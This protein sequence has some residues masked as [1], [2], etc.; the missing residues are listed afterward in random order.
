MPGSISSISHR[1]QSPGLSINLFS[2]TEEHEAQH[3]GNLDIKII[4]GKVFCPKCLNQIADDELHNVEESQYSSY[5]FNLFGALGQHGD[6]DQLRDIVLPV[7][8]I[9]LSHRKL[10]ILHDDDYHSLSKIVHKIVRCRKFDLNEFSCLVRIQSGISIESV[11]PI[12]LKSAWNAWNQLLEYGQIHVPTSVPD[13]DKGFSDSYTKFLYSLFTIVKSYL[14]LVNSHEANHISDL[15]FPIMIRDI[16][17]VMHR[18]YYLESQTKCLKILRENLLPSCSYHISNPDKLS[19]SEI[20]MLGDI[21]DTLTESIKTAIR[22]ENSDYISWLIGMDYI[23]RSHSL[24]YKTPSIKCRDRIEIFL[25]EFVLYVIEKE[26][27]RDSILRQHVEIESTVQTSARKVRSIDNYDEKYKTIVFYILLNCAAIKQNSEYFRPSRVRSVI[28]DDTEIM[29]EVRKCFK[30]SR[31]MMRAHALVTAVVTESPSGTNAA[32]RF[33]RRIWR[34]M[35]RN[36]SREEFNE[37]FCFDEEVFNWAH[38]HHEFYKLVDLETI[39]YCVKISSRKGYLDRILAKLLLGGYRNLIGRQ[40]RICHTGIIREIIKLNPDQIDGRLMYD[41]AILISGLLHDSILRALNDRDNAKCLDYLMQEM[42]ALTVLIQKFD[43]FDPY[44][45]ERFILDFSQLMEEL[46]Q[47]HSLQ[48]QRRGL[49]ISAHDFMA[50]L[51]KTNHSCI[52]SL[53]RNLD[54]TLLGY[55]Y[56]NIENRDTPPELMESIAE[57]LIA[58]DDLDY[59]FEH[60]LDRSLYLMLDSVLDW[61]LSKST[62]LHVLA[63]KLLKKV[64]TD[65]FHHANLNDNQRC[66]LSTGFIHMIF[67]DRDII[68][69]NVK[70][71]STILDTEDVRYNPLCKHLLLKIPSLKTHSNKDL[72]T[73]SMPPSPDLSFESVDGEFPDESFS[74]SK[75]LD[76]LSTDIP[77]G[78]TESDIPT[79]IYLSKALSESYT[80]TPTSMSTQDWERR[81]YE[82]S[83][84]SY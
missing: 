16:H 40:I 81:A 77:A 78:V 82:T 19:E 50:N 25:K 84:S 57:V 22:T 34:E 67:N 72:R 15:V 11:K 13:P 70:T 14:R 83:Q 4:D 46:Y 79:N 44:L 30:S 8:E 51:M 47:T 36:N 31:T 48:P 75:I 1:S 45:D 55:M 64:F 26:Y 58:Y 42:S 76:Q 52:N 68:D 2:L 9:F 73:V 69:N 74:I 43:K 60:R 37:I 65:P 49:L 39:K 17:D 63:L 80:Q 6:R 7:L 21:F 27:G 54:F 23:F 61:A 10:R 24:L 38:R 56:S 41:L 66:C 20:V 71:I 12:P 18:K 3:V 29:T 32:K 28:G 53:V 35:Q 33:I 5:I 62:S 59:P